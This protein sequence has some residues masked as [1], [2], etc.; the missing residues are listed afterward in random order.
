MVIVEAMAAGVPVIAT[1]VG[2]TRHL[3]AEG[4]TGYLIRPGDALTLT[5]RLNRLLANHDLRGRFGEAA[6]IRA[7]EDYRADRVAERTVEVYRRALA[8]PYT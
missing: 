8:D 3:V 4:E 1:D 2:G 7:G 6:R 5:E